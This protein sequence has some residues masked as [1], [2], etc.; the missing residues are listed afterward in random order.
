MYFKKLEG[1]RVYLSPMT[2]DDVNDYTKWMND[3]KVTDNIHST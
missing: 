3:R 2:L 1:K